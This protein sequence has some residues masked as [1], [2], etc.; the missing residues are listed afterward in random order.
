MAVAFL[1]LVS[2]PQPQP[3][4]MTIKSETGKASRYGYVGDPY[5]SVGKF[6]CEASLTKKF[7]RAKWT[8]MKE[9]GV[10]HR[11][12][13]CG[14]PIVICK[15]KV[16]CINAWVVDRGPFGAL[17]QKGHWYA[18]AK[19]K[20]GERYR[21]IVDLLPM[22]SQKLNVYGIEPVTLFYTKKSHKMESQPIYE[23]TWKS[24]G[25]PCHVAYHPSLKCLM[26]YVGLPKNH[27]LYDCDIDEINE[28]IPELKDYSK[29][30]FAD[31]LI[32]QPNCIWWLGFC[33]FSQDAFLVIENQTN[34]LAQKLYTLW[35][36]DWKKS[37]GS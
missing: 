35:N 37:Y 25:F 9:M 19:L 22:P 18:R 33:C 3:K 4:L 30:I 6:A 26:A 16:T 27:A 31:H 21:G 1:F 28:K 8:K 29:L 10:A 34:T 14:T 32:G 2:L 13:P 11:T 36:F 20:P 17:D 12:L 23:T 7:G 5:D 24:S 15:D